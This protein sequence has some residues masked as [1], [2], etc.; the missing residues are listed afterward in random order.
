MSVLVCVP[1]QRDL[2]SRTAEAAFAICANHAAGA[3]FR[4]VRAH[5]VDRCRN[6]CA[7]RFLSS[8]HGHLLFLD[9]DIVPPANA[10][11]LML[12]VNQPLV[13][14]IYPLL[15]V[16]DDRLCGSVAIKSETGGY[17]FLRDFP[18]EPFEADACGL[19]C[20]LIAREVFE[21]VEFPWFK[22]HVQSDLTQS[23]EDIWFFERCA[24]VGIKPMIVP[25][26]LCS[27][28]RSIDLLDLFRHQRETARELSR[29]R[30]QLESC[31]VS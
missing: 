28:H 29:V 16:S 11:D 7:K 12:A 22:F 18:D 30:S 9:S 31:A 5:P 13:C 6:I 26:V 15:V 8:P 14:G 17:H 2:D 24:D 19:G 1:T 21:R 10:L 25:H 4:S 27:H 23:G 20:C 3:S